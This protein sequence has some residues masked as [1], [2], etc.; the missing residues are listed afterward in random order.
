MVLVASELGK[1]KL[2]KKNVKNY[3]L[4]SPLLSL[5]CVVHNMKFE[6]CIIAQKRCILHLSRLRTSL[7]TLSCEFSLHNENPW[8]SPQTLGLNIKSAKIIKVCSSF[9]SSFY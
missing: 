2:M 3:F 7:S 8:T 1:I 6:T 9:D 4:L 5:N